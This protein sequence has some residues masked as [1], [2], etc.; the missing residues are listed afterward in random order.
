MS[1]G[2]ESLFWNESWRGADKQR[3]EKYIGDFD[4]KP[5]AIIGEMSLSKAK[6]VCDAGCGCGVYAL[7]LAMNGFNVSGFES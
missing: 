2:T 3:I 5:D 1:N 4:F 6:K 7:K